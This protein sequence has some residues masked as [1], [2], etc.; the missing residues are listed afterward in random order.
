M[1]PDAAIARDSRRIA[2]LALVATRV[3]VLIVGALAVMVVGTWPAPVAAGLWRVSSNEILNLLARWDSFW[4]YS[5]ATVGYHWD[6]TVFRHE[7]VVFFP[8]YP[9]LMRWG[10]G[11]AGGSPLLAGLTVSLVSF[12]IAIAILYRL[13][14]EDLGADRARAGIL[15]LATYPFALFYSTVYTESLFLMLAAAV[16]YAMRRDH[17]FIAAICGLAA[18]LTRPN[19]FWLGV[20][21]LLIVASRRRDVPTGRLVAGIAASAMPF[22][23]VLAYSGYLRSHFGDGL[24]WVHG[25]AAW[26]LQALLRP[27]AKDEVPY[28]W[29]WSAE[30]T[31]VMNWIFNIG[32]FA[33]AACS[34]MPIFRRFGAPYAVW[35]AL[36]IFPPVATHLF[37]SLGRFTAVLFPVFFW[38]ATIVPRSR[39]VQVAACFAALQ[40]GFA[41]LFFLWRPIV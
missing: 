37:M 29:P 5:I 24:A 23:G 30:F 28:P 15:L 10:S 22:L 34:L 31:D 38:L 6:P 3:P 8:L 20:P 39:L 25:Q 21:M 4:Y 27:G 36:N 26:G 14:C 1:S 13:A 32:A 12:T 17:L 19:G 11:F 41:T 2:L 16:F 18:G 35:I 7:N 9:L 40:L 33:I